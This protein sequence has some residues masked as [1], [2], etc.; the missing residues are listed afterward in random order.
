MH[1]PVRNI[2]TT[3]PVSVSVDLPVDAAIELMQSNRIRRLPVVSRTGSV[4][5]IITLF[6]AMLALKQVADPFGA[7]ADIP[8]VREAMTANV[9]TVGPDDSIAD[10]ARLMLT[11]KIGGLPVV[12]N[13]QLVGMCT[14]SDLFRFLVE[15]YDKE[16]AST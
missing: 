16:Q 13:H 2:M 12:E 11:H 4:A 1:R 6:D 5:G 8:A 15:Q 10:A 3:D 14:E 9:I 7:E